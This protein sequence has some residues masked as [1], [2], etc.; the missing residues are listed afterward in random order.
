MGHQSSNS[1]SLRRV[2][3]D[4]FE[5][6]NFFYIDQCLGLIEPLL[7]QNRDM[8]AAGENLGFATVLLE[9]RAGF[10]DRRRFQVIEVLHNF[11]EKSPAK[12]QSR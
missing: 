3:L 8:S 9:Q 6:G 2:E 5:L 1:E 11:L 10:G 12:A 4:S 7:H